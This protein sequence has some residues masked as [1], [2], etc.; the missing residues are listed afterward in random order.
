MRGSG[1]GKNLLWAQR[2][3]VSMASWKAGIKLIQ[4]R[5][6]R[7]RGQP[8]RDAAPCSP[9]NGVPPHQALLA[10]PNAPTPTL[11]IWRTPSP[12]SRWPTA[13]WETPTS[14]LP[15]RPNPKPTLCPHNVTPP[16]PGG[17]SLRHPP[18][19]GPLR[20]GRRRCL[21]AVGCAAVAPHA[22]GP[23]RGAQRHRLAGG[24]GAGG[25]PHAA[26]GAGGLS[27]VVWNS[28]ALL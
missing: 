7:P 16:R 20:A 1:W 4:P 27:A 5:P 18:L 9:A 2:P 12:A 26:P 11:Q 24:Q 10:H 21:R 6:L 3:T 14:T 19:A 15:L 13:C 25:G 28:G 17:Q 22:G 23:G 8:L